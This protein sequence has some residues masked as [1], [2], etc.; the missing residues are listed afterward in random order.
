MVDDLVFVSN[1]SI[2]MQAYVGAHFILIAVP[3][4]CWLMLPVNSKL[5]FKANSAMPKRYSVG[6]RKFSVPIY[7]G[8]A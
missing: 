1:S 4:I 6:N 3:E 2:Y 7:Q 8:L 5:L